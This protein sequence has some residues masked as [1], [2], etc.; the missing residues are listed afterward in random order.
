MDIK[1]QVYE[2]RTIV[3]FGTEFL[4]ISSLALRAGYAS[5]FITSSL[6]SSIADTSGIG[7]GFGIKLFGTQTDYSY[8]P[9]GILGNTHRI[10]FSS[11]F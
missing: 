7:A 6:N 2:N 11:K 8:A 4:P 1:Q 3:S 5:H 9:Y 10:S